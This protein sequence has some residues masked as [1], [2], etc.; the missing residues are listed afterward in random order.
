MTGRSAEEMAVLITNDVAPAGTEPYSADWH[1]W[2]GFALKVIRAARRH[3]A[4]AAAAKR[5]KS[6]A[7]YFVFDDS[8]KELVPM[9]GEWRETRH[10]HRK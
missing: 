7:Q 3:E 9:R 10:G 5:K 8:V 4:R 6:Q 1:Y 2:R